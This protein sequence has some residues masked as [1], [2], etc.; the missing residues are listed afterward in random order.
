MIIH[1]STTAR[2]AASSSRRSITSSAASDT[3]RFTKNTLV[4][5]S[6]VVTTALTADTSPKR[7][8]CTRG[9]PSIST[10]R[11]VPRPRRDVSEK[12]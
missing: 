8:L 6:S 7:A 1:D 2:D 3:E 9:A 5:A 4:S 11:A 10:R 12:G